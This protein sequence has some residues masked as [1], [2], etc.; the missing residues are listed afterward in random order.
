MSITKWAQ[1]RSLQ[2]SKQEK[3]SCPNS[4]SELFKSLSKDNAILLK[5]FLQSRTKNKLEDVEAYALKKDSSLIKSQPSNFQKKNIQESLEKDLKTLVKSLVFLAESDL[6]KGI[7]PKQFESNIKRNIDSEGQRLIDHSFHANEH[8]APEDYRSFLSSSRVIPGHW[9]EE[10][11]IS[12]KL[13]HSVKGYDHPEHGYINFIEPKT[14]MTKPYHQAVDSE[15][16]GATHFPTGGWAT[17]TTKDLYHAG[18]IGDLVENVSVHEHDNTPVTV[19]SFNPKAESILYH[20]SGY[21]ENNMK[22]LPVKQIGIMDYLTNNTDRHAGNL[23]VYEYEP[24]QYKPLAIDHER[25]FGYGES[26]A[27]S[28]NKNHPETPFHYMMNG[29]LGIAHEHVELTDHSDVIDWWKEKGKNIQKAFAKNLSSIKDESIRKHLYDNFMSRWNRM[30][31]WVNHVEKNGLKT[32]HKAWSDFEDTPI[33]KFKQPLNQKFFES[34]PKNPKDAIST[35]YDVVNRKF[36]IDGKP[37][38]QKQ[39]AQVSEAI[40]NIIK[41]LDPQQLA[42]IY[43]SSKGNPHWNSDGI[44]AHFSKLNVR[45]IIM[46]HL[47]NPELYQDGTPAYKLNHI[48]AISDIIDSDPEANPIARAHSDKLKGILVKHRKGAA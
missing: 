14:F 25:A 15:F 38:N 32:E 18:G 20:R 34:L 44:K 48:Q 35:I 9:D 7:D 5:S 40:H 13:V 2:K 28:Q 39:I 31:E 1:K 10:Q 41:N 45:P 16:I 21:K 36:E 29:G 46:N 30:D 42:D 43:R 12:P 33:K 26:L 17:I 6:L 47:Y 23:L 22:H 11:G 3:F 4:L 24:G 27:S 8:P 19:H 37:L